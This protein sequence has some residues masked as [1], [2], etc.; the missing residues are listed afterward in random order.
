MKTE[1]IDAKSPSDWTPERN[2]GTLALLGKGVEESGE[3]STILAR[4]IIQGVAGADPDTGEPNIEA[5]MDEIADVSALNSMII[6]RLNLDSEKIW[7]RQARKMAYKSVW[8]AEL[9]KKYL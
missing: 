5:L 8:I 6:K 9:D 3:L 4:C 7:E 1:D 2:I